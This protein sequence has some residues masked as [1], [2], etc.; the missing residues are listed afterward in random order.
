MVF[1]LLNGE[2][3]ASFHLRRELLARRPPTASHSRVWLSLAGKCYFVW[4]SDGMSLYEPE[5]FSG[6][7][8]RTATVPQSLCLPI[9]LSTVHVFESFIVYLNSN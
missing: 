2:Q 4:R 5:D 3:H 7:S 9:T 8:L 1:R 6:T